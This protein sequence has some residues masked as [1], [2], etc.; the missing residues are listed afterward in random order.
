MLNKFIIS[1]LAATAFT[2]AGKD[3]K[4]DEYIGLSRQDKSEKIWEKVTA[5]S[6]SGKWHFLE[7][8]TVS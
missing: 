2:K 1:L 3:L 4:G 7:T 5:N 8:L 6:K